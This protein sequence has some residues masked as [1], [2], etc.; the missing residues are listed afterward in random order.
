MGKIKKGVGHPCFARSGHAP[1]PLFREGHPKI[2]LSVDLY[3]MGPVRFGTP[4]TVI[5]N[6]G[7]TGA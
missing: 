2:I 5:K 6:R 4:P 1:A 7:G 3:C